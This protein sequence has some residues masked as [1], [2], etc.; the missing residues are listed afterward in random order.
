MQEQYGFEEHEE[1]NRSFLGSILG[2]ISASAQAGEQEAGEEGREGESEAKEEQPEVPSRQEEE[3]RK[4]EEEEEEEETQFSDL[5]RIG[6]IPPGV[7]GRMEEQ[8]FGNRTESS[9]SLDA[10][11]SLPSLEALSLSSLPPGSQ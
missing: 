3:T 1:I 7:W 4:E 9:G 2:F 10:P 8:I 6:E 5:E 11:F